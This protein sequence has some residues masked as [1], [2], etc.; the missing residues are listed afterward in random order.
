MIAI[1]LI[2]LNKIIPT[3][4][5][6]FTSIMQ[7]ATRFNTYIFLALCGSL[8]GNFGLEIVSLLMSFVIIFKCFEY[9]FLSDLSRFIKI[10]IRYF[11]NL[12]SKIL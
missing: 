6:S 7:G 8:Y 5:G 12:F 1:F 4:N 9:H 2:I 3:S 11:L 10:N